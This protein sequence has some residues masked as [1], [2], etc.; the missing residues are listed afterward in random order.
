MGVEPTSGSG[1]VS[2][3]SGQS[4]SEQPSITTEGAFASDFPTT[5]KYN[6][7]DEITRQSKIFSQIVSVQDFVMTGRK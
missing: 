7:H 4:G 5:M 1:L 3:P 6:H 2:L